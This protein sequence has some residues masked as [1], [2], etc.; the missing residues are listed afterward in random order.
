MV[1]AEQEKMRASEMVSPTTRI[2]TYSEIN[3]L[4]FTHL[5]H[6]NNIFK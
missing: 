1:G 4:L 2:L 6:N 5:Y 3:P